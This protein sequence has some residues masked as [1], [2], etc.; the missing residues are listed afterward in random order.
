[1][2]FRFIVG[3]LDLEFREEV[4]SSFEKRKVSDELPVVSRSSDSS[5]ASAVGSIS[6]FENRHVSDE[7]PVVGIRCWVDLELHE[8]GGV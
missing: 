4:I 1:M 3:W 6:S 7:L 5:A 2:I 8:E